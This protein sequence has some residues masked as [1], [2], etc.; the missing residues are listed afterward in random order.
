MLNRTA[1]VVWALALPAF[2]QHAGHAGQAPA[3][4]A[5][6]ASASAPT[7]VAP[8]VQ[9][10]SEGHRSAFSGYRRFA[11]E[12]IQDWKAANDRVSQIGGWRAYA[13]EAA[14]G[15]DGGTGAH[16]AHGAAKSASDQSPPRAGAA[17]TDKPFGQTQTTQPALTAPRP[18][19]AESPTPPAKPSRPASA[20]QPKGGHAHH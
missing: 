4:S 20:P 11:D 17:N 16:A 10:A 15:Q 2:A 8:P 18:T 5:Q 13:A 6:S 7:R 14:S 3:A 1:A 9:P 12:P 19:H